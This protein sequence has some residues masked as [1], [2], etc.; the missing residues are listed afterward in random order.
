ML[1]G[2]EDKARHSYIRAPTSHNFENEVIAEEVGED[3]VAPEEEVSTASTKAVAS[4]LQIVPPH[5]Y[6]TDELQVLLREVRVASGD[7]EAESKRGIARTEVLAL[8]N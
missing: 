4:M 1:E 8:E 5:A 3:S 2:E 7:C 6:Q